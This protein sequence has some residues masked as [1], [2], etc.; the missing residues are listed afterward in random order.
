M[1]EWMVGLNMAWFTLPI[2]IGCVCVIAVLAY[3]DWREGR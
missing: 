1:P 3:K 2:L